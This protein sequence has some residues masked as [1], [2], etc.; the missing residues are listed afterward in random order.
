[1][2]KCKHAATTCKQQ[3]MTD[4]LVIIADTLD[5]GVHPYPLAKTKRQGPTEGNSLETVKVP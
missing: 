1:M 3:P 4:I 5:W 2:S